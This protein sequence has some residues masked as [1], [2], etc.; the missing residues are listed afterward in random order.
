VVGP[1]GFSVADLKTIQNWILEQRF[2]AL[3]GV[4]DV[5]GRDGKTKAYQITVDLDRLLAYGVTLPQVLQVLNTDQLF[6][7]SALAKP[8]LAKDVM[9]SNGKLC[10]GEALITNGGTYNNARDQQ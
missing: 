4:I 3:P 1:P 6:V 10:Q 9:A 5:T 8:P 7:L 2:K